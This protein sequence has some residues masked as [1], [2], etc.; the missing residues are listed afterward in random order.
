MT[1]KAVAYVR[2]SSKDQEREGFS[3]PAQRKLLQDYAK[4]NNF[5]IAVFFEEAETAKQA[6]RKQFKRM[7]D[8]LEQNPDIKDV[9]VEKVD[10]M[11]RNFHDSVALQKNAKHL[12]LHFVK[13]SKILSKDSKSHEVLHHDIDLAVANYHVRNLSE[14]V[15]KG[16]DEKAAQGG[17]PGPAPLGYKNRLEDHTIVVHPE[18]S[19][20]IKKAF[21]LAATG[22]YSLLKLNKEMY[23]SGLRSKRSKNQLSKS[24]MSR[25]L[26]NP[27]YYGYFWRKGVLYK[28]NH[29]PIISK[30]LFDRVQ[31]TMGYVKTP[32]L[33]KRQLTYRGLMTCAHCGCT[34]T[35][36]TKKN[37]YTYY[38]CTNGKGI[39]E[40]VKNRR[41]EYLE[42]EFKNALRQIKLPLEVVKWTE[43]ELE[44]T[45]AVGA[46]EKETHLANLKRRFRE[47]EKRHSEA[48]DRYLDGKIPEELWELKSKQLEDEKVALKN[49][50]ATLELE[51]QSEHKSLIPLMDLASKA[52]TL[53]DSMN[54]DEKRELM[55]LVLSN[56][57]IKNGSLC[58]DFRF[59]FS[60]FVGVSHLDK[61]RGGRDSNPRPSA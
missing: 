14:E 49:Q 51:K 15:K 46:K 9:L 59:P 31:S 38:R 6:G 28:A 7:L 29:K 45:E 55:N 60:K 26:N 34:I 50:L 39:C 5:Q 1:K 23:R 22:Q 24:S 12:S 33:A 47:I 21:E 3:I 56:P 35:G 43:E 20:L 52:P 19:V 36:E 11:Y 4:E 10:R 18:E 61:W 30:D 44:R 40:F 17:W 32:H 25:V 13:Q 54:S 42:D 2:V 48:C 16:S 41:E 27:F 53:F 8:F 57:Q 37:R 58:Y